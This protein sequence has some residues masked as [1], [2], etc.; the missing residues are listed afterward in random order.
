VHGNGRKKIAA[1]QVQMPAS[2]PDRFKT[3]PSKGRNG[4]TGGHD[5]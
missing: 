3:E 1:S 5:G 4:L 2:L